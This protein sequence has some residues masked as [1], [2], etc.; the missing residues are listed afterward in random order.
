M[1]PINH[2]W[3]EGRMIDLIKTTPQ[4]DWATQEIEHLVEEWRA[5]HALYSPL[6]QRREPRDAAYTSLQG[7]LATWP[8]QSMAPMVLAIAGVAPK[9]VRAMPAFISA[10]QGN[11]ARLLHRHGEA[12]DPDLGG[13]DGVRRVEG[14]DVPKPGGHAVGV[15]R[16]DGGALGK[17]ANGQAGVCVGD[18]SSQG[19]TVLD[20]RW[21][22]PAAWCTE[23]AYAERRR[24]CGLPPEITCKTKPEV[25]QARRTAVVKSQAL[26]CRGVG[27]DEACG[28]HPGV[29]DGVAGR[30]LWYVADVPHQTRVWEA[31]PAT[32][33]PSWRGR[34]RR[35][36]RERLGAGAPEARTVL[37]MAAGLAAEAWTRQTLQEGRQGPMVAECAVR[38]VTAVRD[39]LPGPDVW[40]VRRRQVETG[41][42]KTYLGH[43]PVDTAVATLVRMS[44]RRWPL[45]TCVEDGKHR[46]GMG[47]DA[48]RSWT[49]WHHQ[50]T[51]VMLAHVFVVRMSLR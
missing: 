16:Q 39:A 1:R 32:R 43:A 10:G 45:E 36:Q 42:L 22:V 34:G 20:R 47:D 35:P 25:A 23:D 26:R 40:L 30:G 27:A 24:P 21:S 19:Y 3:K 11:A 41:E 15:K 6:C 4:R 17:R 5:D 33:L 18:A 29:L 9:A 49:G 28:D 13:D 12:G 14:R 51:W 44:G 2:A 37:G 46:L 31:R 7:L 48:V 38:R 50:M 8:R